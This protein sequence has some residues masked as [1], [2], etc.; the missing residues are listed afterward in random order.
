MIHH[1]GHRENILIKKKKEHKIFSSSVHSISEYD[2][3]YNK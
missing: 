2:I 1:R 3:A